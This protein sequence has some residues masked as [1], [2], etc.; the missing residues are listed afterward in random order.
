VAGS[1]SFGELYLRCDKGNP[2]EVYS[3]IE[4]IPMLT[5]FG[6]GQNDHVTIDNL[7]LKYAN[8]AVQG[9]GYIEG[10]HVTNCEIGWIGG[11]I[12]HYFGTDPNYPQGRRG[13]VTRFGNGIEIYGGCDDY[14]VENCY[15]YQSYDAGMTHQVT[16]TGK[17]Y[18]MTNILYKNNLIEKCVYAIEYF[19][20]K[21]NMETESYIDGCEMCGNILRFSGYGWGQQRH[22]THTPA[23]IKGWSYENTARNFSVYNNIFDRSAYRMIHMVAK[24]NAS[25][26]NMYENTYIQKYGMTL[27]VYGAYEFAEPETIGFFDNAEEKIRKDYGDRDAKVFFLE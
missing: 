1:T 12:Q 27:G 14:V 4:S 8:F 5:L 3:E 23:H 9:G 18:I 21:R 24:E 2:A 7:C 22:N 16:T 25:C 26:A 13:T 11:C 10:L 19:L 20:E 6:L 15:I 17:K